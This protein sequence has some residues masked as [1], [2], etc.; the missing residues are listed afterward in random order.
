M[1]D[2]A[3]RRIGHLYPKVQLPTEHGGGEATVIAWLWARTVNCPNPA[4]GTRMPLIRSFWLSTKTGKK[5]W[6]EPVSNE[7]THCIQFAIRYGNPSPNAELRISAGAGYLTPRG[8]TVKATFRCVACG[9]GPVKGDYIDSQASMSQ[10]GTMAVAVVAGS[11]GGRVFLPPNYDHEQAA[12]ALASA[13]L[14]KGDLDTTALMAPCQG[15]FASNAMGRRYGFRVFADYFTD[16]QLVALATLSDLVAQARDQALSDAIIA[17]WSQYDDTPKLGHPGANEYADAIATYLAL[18]LSR[19]TDICNSLCRWESSKTQVRNLYGRQA[20]PM[21]WDFAEPNVFAMAAG[22]YA[23]SLDSLA[24]ALEQTPAK[25]AGQAIQQDVATLSAENVPVVISTDPPYYGN[26]GYADL[27]DFFYVWLRRSLHAVYPDLFGTLLVPKNEELVATRYRFGGNMKTAEKF[28]EVGLAKAFSRVRSVQHHSYPLTIYYAF[29]QAEAGNEHAPDGGSSTLASTGWETMLTGLLTAGFAITGTWPVRSE[30]GNRMVASDAN[31]LASSIL[32]VC[33]PRP[34]ESLI[35]TRRDFLQALKRELPE[36]LRMLQHGNIAPVD[37]AQAAI[38]P[39]MAVYSRYSRVIEP[40]GSPLPV[41][42]ALALINQT[43]DEVLAE[44]EGEFDADTRWALAWFQQFSMEEAPFGTAET[45]ST[46]KNTS[47]AGMVQAG[48]LHA[49][50]GKVRLVKRGELSND[51]NPANDTRLTV[52]ETAQHLIRTLQNDGE[53]AAAA[54]L[55]AAGQ[56]GQNARD[57]AYRLYVI[58]ERKGW[59]SEALAYNSLVTT[60]SALGRTATQ[61]EE[62][63]REPVQGTLAGIG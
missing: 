52:W 54:L 14:E 49:G 15:T 2:E 28:F 25:G 29:K 35:S 27:S 31:A 47:V 40:D 10:L 21:V 60:W 44:Q 57:L 33:R 9:S 7:S 30:L 59:A 42:A 13:Q 11:P 37:L 50:G 1:R 32:L 41:R 55:V 43:L 48:I 8:K 22:D 36:A 51:W 4:C 16:R 34:V 46:A 26:V 62:Q 18:G 24:K 5:A 61:M 45:L 20:I 56:A 23:I 39:G 19:M 6:L 17:G 53:Q 3:F 38:G 58:C 63:K 12:S